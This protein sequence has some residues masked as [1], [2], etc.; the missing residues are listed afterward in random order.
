MTN[1]RIFYAGFPNHV[2]GAGTECQHTIKLWRDHG[3]DVHLIPTWGAPA[4]DLRQ[5][6]DEMGCTTHVVK[7]YE[8]PTIDGLAGSPV[9]SMCNVAFAREIHRFRQLHC[10]T[11]WLN[12]MTYLQSQE[13]KFWTQHGIPDVWIFQS[14]FQ[15][16]RLQGMLLANYH[17]NP[18]QGHLI[19]GA[20]DWQDWDFAPRK[21]T[22]GDPFVVGKLARPNPEK[23]CPYLWR[24][25]GEIPNVQAI[26]M[27]ITDQGAWF[28]LGPPPS[29]ARVLPAGA[30]PV[31]QFYSQLHAL[32]TV[33]GG[34]LENWPRIGLEAMAAG[35][36]IVAENKW[37]WREMIEHGV[38]GFLGDDYGEI[39]HYAAQLEADE[40]LRLNIA[41]HAREWLESFLAEPDQIWGGW[42]NVFEAIGREDLTRPM[43]TDGEIVGT[44]PTRKPQKQIGFGE[45]SD[46]FT[47]SPQD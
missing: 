42:C 36:P 8:L 24:I 28:G 41:T 40:K 2:G 1:N 44:D 7:P 10:P 37:G 13:R 19:R 22:P 34:D 12:C 5:L 32:V 47:P 6:A 43:E 30:M 17:Y 18:N 27:G 21:R 16:D 26:C 29:F 3:I 20:F 4:A 9:V 45:Y 15:R 14:Q 39:S 11:I 23:W 33:N 35:V 46:T 38:T 25:Y 31:K